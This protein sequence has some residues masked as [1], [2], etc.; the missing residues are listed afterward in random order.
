MRRG[1]NQEFPFGYGAFEALINGFKGVLVPGVTVMAFV[2]AVEALLA[3]GRAIAAGAV[4]VVYGVFATLACWGLAFATHRAA[5]RTL[6]PLIKTD[7]ENWIINGAIST[8][9]MLLALIGILAMQGTNLAP[10][11]P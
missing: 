3:G 4:I 5:K 10:L 11:I 2:D 7:A 9:V 6:S 8:A 1:D